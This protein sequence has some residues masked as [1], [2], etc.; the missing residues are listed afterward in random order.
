LQRSIDLTKKTVN[1]GTTVGRE[2]ETTI[3]TD[4]FTGKR[5]SV[6]TRAKVT[7]VKGESTF[8]STSL[9]DGT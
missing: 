1:V 6:P 9:D 3:E 4:P 7:T 2:R 8:S 5:Y